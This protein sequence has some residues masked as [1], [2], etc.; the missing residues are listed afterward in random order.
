MINAFKYA[1]VS[2]TQK[3]VLLALADCHNGITGRCDPSIQRIMK[4]TGLS[5]RAIAT[6]LQHQGMLTVL[7]T[8][9]ALL[10][11]S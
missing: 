6:A 11:A 9:G 4:F 2:Y 3:L 7:R 10:K 5:N 8:Q 1:P